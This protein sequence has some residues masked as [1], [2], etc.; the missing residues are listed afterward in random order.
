MTSSLSNHAIYNKENSFASQSL[1][2]YR[3]AH[4]GKAFKIDLGYSNGPFL[5]KD[6]MHSNSKSASLLAAKEILQSHMSMSNMMGV[7]TK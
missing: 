2:L 4:Q 5:S 7:L 3:P 6:V 1:S